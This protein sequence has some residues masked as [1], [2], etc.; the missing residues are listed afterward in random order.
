MNHYR[1]VV[2]DAKAESVK[3]YEMR[4]FHAGSANKMLKWVKDSLRT[5]RNW[6]QG[7][8]HFVAVLDK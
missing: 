2:V 1:F 3:F 8:H 4:E 6:L 7:R 5:A